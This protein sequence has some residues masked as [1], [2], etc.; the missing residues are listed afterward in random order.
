MSD[1]ARKAGVS[2]MTASC[3]LNERNDD[4]NVR[5]DTRQKVLQAAAELGYRRN[6][7]ARAMVTGKNRVLGFLAVEPETEYVA[8]MLSGALDE[9][10]EHDYLV[11]VM[12]IGSEEQTRLALRRCSE[13]RLAGIITVYMRDDLL[14]HLHQEMARF[15]IPLARL[16][17]SSARPWGVR[18]TSDD[19]M[20]V[21]EA[22][23]YLI[24]LGHRKIAFVSGSP[25]AMTCT[26]RENGYLQ[27]MNKA[28]LRV[29]PGYLCHGYWD[30]R[31]TKEVTTQLLQ[32]PERPTAILCGNDEVAMTVLR[33]ARAHGLRLPQDLSVVGFADLSIARMADPPL[34]TV[35][36]PF[37]EMGHVA[38][39]WLL[40]RQD[41]EDFSDQ[42][43]E[44]QLPTRLLVR[45][46]TTA[47]PA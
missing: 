22:V 28:G 40:A 24:S 39:R 13:T 46:S 10:E 41:Q 27:G 6:E 30:T 20:G 36:Q 38:V 4:R 25:G 43:V 23:E 15:R 21:S 8:R 9:A 34:T 17:S 42:P 7:L 35:S 31:I 3:V 1:I 12:R 44:E 32:H 26:A 16:D 47:P 5:D 14:D 11:K 29:L 18:V 19:A 45:E 37:K 33:T 2:R